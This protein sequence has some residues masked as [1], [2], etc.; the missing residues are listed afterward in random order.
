MVN[1]EESL[2]PES[3]LVFLSVLIFIHL[4]KLSIFMTRW[5]HQ[6]LPAI[7]TGVYF[8]NFANPRLRIKEIFFLKVVAPRKFP[9][10]QRR[11][12]VTVEYFMTF[13]IAIKAYVH[14]TPTPIHVLSFLLITKFHWKLKEQSNKVASPESTTSEIKL[15]F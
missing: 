11:S 3:F 2:N 5:K 12:H 8:I 4:M 6:L 15:Y 10:Q 1:N 13:C 14:L 7:T 9:S